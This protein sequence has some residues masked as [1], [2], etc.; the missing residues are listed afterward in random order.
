MKPSEAKRPVEPPGLERKI[1]RWLPKATAASTLVPLAFYFYVMYY[2]PIPDGGTAEKTLMTAG[3][4][5]VAVA[6]TLLTAIFTVAIGCW[7]VVVMKGPA[8]Y[9]D[10][11]PLQDAKHPAKEDKKN[12][13]EP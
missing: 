7:I 4:A 5:A 13:P 6:I 1:L 11:Y 2:P 8:R 12:N 10:S 9:A 3:I